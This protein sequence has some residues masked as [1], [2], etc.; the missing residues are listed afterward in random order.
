LAPRQRSSSSLS[1]RLLCA[2]FQG[3]CRAYP[4]ERRG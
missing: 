2:F 4:L 1:P 3:K